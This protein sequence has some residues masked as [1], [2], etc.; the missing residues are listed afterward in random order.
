LKLPRNRKVLVV[1]DLH[2]PFTLPKYLPFCISLYK[3][4]KCN[5]V[6]F[7]G[8]IIDNH[9][10]SFHDTDPE[11]HGGAKEFRLAYDMIQDWYKAFPEAMVCLGNHDTLPDRKMFNAGVVNN[12][13]KSMET[14]LDTPNWVYKERFIIDGV[15]YTHGIGRK[16][17]TRMK[18]DMISVVQGHYHSDSEIKYLDGDT[19]HNFSM[20]VG[21]GFDGESYAARY[22]KN[23]KVQ[24]AN[25]GVVLNNGTLPIIERML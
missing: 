12:W 25:A 19:H 2:A 17:H 23:Y 9:F 3:K 6:M 22:A 21:C 18:D 24:A 10:T 13:R 5:L 8:D 15:K 1:G 7:L 16:A 20:Q 11:A 4:Y 14:A